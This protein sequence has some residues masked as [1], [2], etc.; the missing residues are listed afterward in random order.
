[1]PGERLPAQDELSEHYGVSAP[2]MREALRILETEGLVTVQRGV[3]G[4]T[5]VNAPNLAAMSRQLSLFL[6]QHGAT[7]AD[8][9]EARLALEP[10]AVRL[11][12][13]HCTPEIAGELRAI[14]AEERE[15][16]ET[17]PRGLGRTSARFHTLLLQRS[18][19]ITLAALGTVISGIVEN[20]VAATVVASGIG[21]RV[22]E[23]GQRELKH[24]DRLVDLLAAGEGDAAERHW[25]KVLSIQYEFVREHGDVDIRLALVS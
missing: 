16:L 19:N 11:L 6:Q 21:D 4:G 7:V 13:A 24:Q 14:I 2:T 15:V 8:A 22:V 1:M 25:R 17:N 20:H 9:Y 18:G 12:A 3:R 23:I 5:I 10:P